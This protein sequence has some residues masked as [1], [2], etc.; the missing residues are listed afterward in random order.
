[1]SRVGSKPWI[2][3]KVSGQSAEWWHFCQ[4]HHS[5]DPHATL[6]HAPLVLTLHP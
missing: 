4:D 2:V 3:L 5:T 6:S 1:M